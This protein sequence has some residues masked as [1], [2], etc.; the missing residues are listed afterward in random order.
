MCEA[1][2]H[3]MTAATTKLMSSVQ[4]FLICLWEVLLLFFI[5]FLHSLLYYF[6]ALIFRTTE[7]QLPLIKTIHMECSFV[8][9]H[10]SHYP[11]PDDD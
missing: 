3:S 7:L 5:I 8:A 2:S 4:Q 6:Y 10:I 11:T 1:Q 9:R